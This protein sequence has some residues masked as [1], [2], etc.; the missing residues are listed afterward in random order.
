VTLER[1]VTVDGGNMFSILTIFESQGYKNITGYEVLL[2]SVDCP[3]YKAMLS[4]P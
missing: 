2:C 3:L 1:G 4:K